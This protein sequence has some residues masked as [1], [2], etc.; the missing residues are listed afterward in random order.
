MPND[1]LETISI[2]NDPATTQFSAAIKKRRR[3]VLA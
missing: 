2:V 1:P 3:G